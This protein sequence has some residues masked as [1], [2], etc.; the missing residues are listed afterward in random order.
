MTLVALL[1]ACTG[2]AAPNRPSPASSR[3]ASMPPTA[4]VP[5]APASESP[6][7]VSGIPG[8]SVDAGFET[9]P[10]I[11]VDSATPPPTRTEVVV[12]RRGPGVLLQQGDLAV[13]DDVGRTWRSSAM[14]ENTYYLGQ[15]PHVFPVGTTPLAL[16]GLVHAL[17]GIPVGS[18]VLVVVPPS[19]GFGVSASRPQGVSAAD[20]AVVVF[21]I[22]GGYRGDA[23]PQGSVVSHGGGQLPSVSWSD[24]H[25]APHVHIPEAAPPQQRRVVTLVKGNGPALQQGN[26]AIV[27]YLAETWSGQLVGSSW[28]RPLPVPLPIGTGALLPGLDQGLVGV[29]VGSRVLIVVPPA[30]GLSASGAPSAGVPRSETLVFVVDVLGA[31][32]T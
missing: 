3:T 16:P 14:Y 13:V 9:E 23:G 11:H 20:T 32:N 8:I 30:E 19:Q 4:T 12:V 21:D 2:H 18:R 29:T 5:A 10:Q 27:Q 1:A 6:L 24:V 31:Y 15:A 26:L 28:D 25:S 17:E 7:L 22:I